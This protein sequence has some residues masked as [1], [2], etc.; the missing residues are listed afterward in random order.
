MSIYKYKA[1]NWIT[2]IPSDNKR[3]I[4]LFKGQ[5]NIPM[6]VIVLS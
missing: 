3:T 2:N 5:L 6:Q 1:Q 4:R